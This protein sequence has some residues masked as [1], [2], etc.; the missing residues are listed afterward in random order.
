MREV[1]RRLKKGQRHAR[2]LAR[3]QN[4]SVA[5]IPDSAD[6]FEIHF[7][8]RLRDSIGASFLSV[9]GSRNVKGSPMTDAMVRVA[10]KDGYALMDIASAE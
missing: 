7:L 10:F 5:L 9:S 2:P 3:R 6:S 1:G 8:A 4:G